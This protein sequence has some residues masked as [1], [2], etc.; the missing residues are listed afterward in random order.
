MENKA[1]RSIN[2]I[3]TA[4]KVGYIVSIFLVI[5]AVTCMVFTAILTAAAIR[6][7]DQEITV[8]VSTGID[9]ES[10]GNFL[11]MLNS[12]IKI[13]G[14]DNLGDLVPEDS[15]TIIAGKD[16]KNADISINDSDLSEISIARK[17]NGL[18]VNA[19]ASENVFSIKR[20]IVCLVLTFVMF[21]TAAFSA[22]TIKW[23]MK[24]LKTCETPFCENV[25]RKMMLF[26]NSL[27]PLIIMNTV[28]DGM[29]NTLGGKASELNLSVNLGSVLLVAVVYLLVV[30]FKYGAQLQQEA[31]ETL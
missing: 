17:G 28:C 8:K 21:G 19:K 13:D 31:D 16:G 14:V 18:T 26:A 22:H 1:N 15:Q 2:T 5:A 30:V 12:F 27:I 23:L 29:W 10:S 11:E 3:N 9:I 24:A 25:I 6:V 7:S 20:I 4:G